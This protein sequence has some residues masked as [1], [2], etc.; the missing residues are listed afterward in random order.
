MIVEKH[1]EGRLLEEERQTIVHRVLIATKYMAVPL[2][3]SFSL[4]DHFFAP[5]LFWQFFYL[6][7]FIIPVGACAYF[8][9]RLKIVRERF[10]ELP[11]IFVCLFLGLYNAYMAM[12]TGGA[13]SPY[14]AGLNLVTFGSLFFLPFRKRYI[15]LMFLAIYGPYFALLPFF[16][17]HLSLKYFVPNVAFMF[18]TGFVGLIVAWVTREMRRKEVEAKISLEFELQNKDRIIKAKTQEA[19]ELEK[20]AI[21]FSPQ[22]I[23]AIKSQQID[24]S[25]SIRQEISCIFID[26]ENSTSRSARIDYSIYSSLLREFFSDCVEILLSH[27]ITVGTYLGDGL[28]A[29]ANAPQMVPEH[30]KMAVDSCL[31]ILSRHHQKSSYYRDKWRTNFNVRIGINTGFAE[32]G[33]FPSAQRGTYTAVGEAVNLASRLMT[34]APPN[35]ICVTRGVLVKMGD[36]LSN[37]DVESL[38]TF[39]NIK[40][41]QGELYDLFS[42]RKKEMK[43]DRSRDAC[44]L[45]GGKL[46]AINDLGETIL[47]RCMKCRYT[48]LIDKSKFSNV[49]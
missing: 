13:A 36:S 32:V 23:S 18:S 46:V 4:V 41:F 11:G 17:E 27:N 7:L 26:L 37:V 49:A 2:V 24:L 47:A 6:R 38:G 45:C 39:D 42:I 19:T 29:F 15:V 22:V 28:L 30:A 40:G 35:S 31:D 48:D 20:L 5:K 16:T 1:I 8:M 25:S 14:Y 3:L 33:F 34:N 10:Y 9:Y 12:V 21:Q 43:Q 44:P